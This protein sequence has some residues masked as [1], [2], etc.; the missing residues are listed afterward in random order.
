MAGKVCAALIHGYIGLVCHHSHWCAAVGGVA[1]T[2]YGVVCAAMCGAMCGVVCGAVCG[3]VCGVW[4]RI[5]THYS[6]T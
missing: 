2:W 1:C 6:F 5:D 3:V 4:C